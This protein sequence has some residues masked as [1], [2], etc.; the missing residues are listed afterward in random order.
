ML[1]N[2]MYILEAKNTLNQELIG[3]DITRG[4]SRSSQTSFIPKEQL[5]S[6]P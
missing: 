3:D 5:D 4:R 2:Q 6:N 1:H